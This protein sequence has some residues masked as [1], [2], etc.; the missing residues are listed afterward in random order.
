MAFY[1]TGV[2]TLF[3]SCDHNRWLTIGLT[4]GLAGCVAAAIILT[5]RDIPVPR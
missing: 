5:R 2:T 4:V 3:S 1:V